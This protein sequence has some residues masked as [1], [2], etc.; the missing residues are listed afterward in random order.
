M[1]LASSVSSLTAKQ[2][3]ELDEQ[4]STLKVVVFFTVLALLVFRA[5]L[6]PG[7]L[8]LTTDDNIGALA[9][10]ESAL[11]F[12]FLGWWFDT[13]L[14]GTP[15]IVNI[16]WS[17]VLLWILPLRFYSNWIHAIDLFIA[18]LGLFSFLRMRGL[19]TTTSIIAGMTF[20]WFGSTFFLIYAG[21]LGKFGVVAFAGL[22]LPLIELAVQR[23]SVAYAILAGAAVGSMIIEQADVG[24][25]FALGIGP[26]VLFALWRDHGKDFGTYLRILVPMGLVA[27]ALAARPILMAQS[28]YAL[29]RSDAGIVEEGGDA[30]WDYC[31]QW[32]WPPEESIEFIAPGYM[33][34]RSGEPEGP[35]WGRM[36]RS[37]EWDRT[38]QGF[39]NFKLETLYMGGI[40]MVLGFL[41]LFAAFSSQRDERLPR[42]EIF[43]WAGV[44]LVTYLLALGKFFPLYRLFYYLP[45][46]SSIRNP[47]KFMQVAQMAWAILAAYGVH[48]LFLAATDETKR[49]LRKYAYAVLG[50]GLLLALWAAG[51]AS[52]TPEAVGRFN[53]E[54]WGQA[55][56]VIVSN[57]VGGL[58][59]GAVLTLFAGAFIV[60]MLS[61]G[62]RSG[63]VR[64]FAPWVC[65]VVMALD[66]LVV[67]RHYVKTMEAKGFI[68]ENEVVKTLAAQRDH[69]RPYL[70][71]QGG[72]YN[73][74]LTY[75]FPYH[76][77]PAFNVTQMRMPD[78]YKQF[79]G[80]MQNQPER[81]WPLCAVSH[82]VGPGQILQQVGADP[83]F[84]GLY[85]PVLAFN[86]TGTP[87]GGV[88][89][90]PA[91]ERQ[92]GQHGIL[93]SAAPPGRFRLIAGWDVAEDSEA[94]RR[95]TDATMP[96]FEKVTVSP[97]TSEGLPVG[98]GLGPAGTVTVKAYRP[99]R[100]VLGVSADRPAMLRIADKFSPDWKARVD[101]VET[102]V[103]RCDYLFQGVYVD[104]GL[105]EVIL[106]YAPSR[107]SLIPQAAGLTACLFALVGIAG[108]RRRA[109]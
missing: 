32:S 33:G 52:S 9:Y 108:R 29:D 103:R 75:L 35:Y 68:D 43:F 87:G 13:V 53:R 79:L 83:R 97:T 34:W 72:F 14:V 74:W 77:L 60:I 101:G 85:T 102:A 36:G 5:V 98:N 27:G 24:L 62:S 3:V 49:A 69:G 94:L 20:C 15:E 54:G 95:L 99:G 57:M 17:N 89:V 78:D 46:M 96:L 42:R 67:S 23:R 82:L 25:F 6:V 30:N 10:R 7:Q 58:T 106:H 107:V 51:L 1:K 59:H 11:P 21:H 48:A 80:A 47:V 88:N 84:K 28:I 73:L 44:A 104:A 63:S 40:P 8:L 81:M 105:H 56:P 109:L 38:K 45:G 16:S 66:L 86:V 65:A 61:L 71:Q 22:A 26:Y 19:S 12:S 76:Q 64:T 2:A 93:R 92:P 91:T 41:A 4:R 70:L 31:T 37:A 18:S 90:I 100:V 39:Q 55:A 50:F